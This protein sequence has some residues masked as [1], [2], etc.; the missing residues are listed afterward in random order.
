MITDDEKQKIL[1]ELKRKL[2][3][4]LIVEEWCDEFRAELVDW[5]DSHNIQNYHFY[6]SLNDEKLFYIALKKTY[7]NER[8]VS[9]YTKN[10]GFKRKFLPFLV[11]MFIIL[12][13][14]LLMRHGFLNVREGSIEQSLMQATVIIFVPLLIGMFIEYISSFENPN[15][16]FWRMGIDS[17]IGLSLLL[18]V[19]VLIF[20][21]G[22][23]CL[24][25]LIPLAWLAIMVGA[26]LMQI[27]C[28]FFWKPTAQIYSLALL[29]L[30]LFLILP[31]LSKHYYGQTQREMIIHATQAQVF[32]AINHIGKI[33]PEEVPNNFIFTMGF[34]KPI[35]GM[36]EQRATGL[37]R[38]IQWERGVQ[39]EEQVQANHKPYLLSWNY[40]FDTNSFPKGSL[41]D[42]VEVGG[43]YFDLLKTDYQLEQVDAK[44]TKLILTIDYR[45]STEFNWYSRLW[46]NYILGEFS[47]VV[48]SIHKHRLEKS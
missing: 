39:F 34:P 24:I 29:P 38:T 15:L 35:F 20:H 42:H 26:G 13:T 44:T 4:T 21:E 9:V 33:K 27:I 10:Q 16:S 47:D 32:Q 30:L 37:V 48:M 18:I 36:T 19:G 1:N 46:V 2:C 8:L 31:D 23:V 6:R 41:D 40:Q 17:L 28:Y 43:K 45:V 7:I 5:L 25:V 11:A 14:V 3:A 22:M 12:F